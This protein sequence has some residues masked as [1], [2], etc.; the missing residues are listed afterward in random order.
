MVG[1]ERRNK[2]LELLN[3][4]LGSLSGS[5]LSKILKVS[6]QVV[7]QDIAILR[8]EGKDIIATP[9]G[10]II[11]DYFSKKSAK[12]IIACK[13]H[14][15]DIGD[16]LNLIIAMGGRILDVIVEHPVYGELKGMLMLSSIMDA[17]EFTRRM[18]ESVSEPLLVLTKGVHLHTIEAD[19]EEKLNMIEEKLREKGY[20]LSEEN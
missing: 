20:L 4:G 18:N 11:P 3:S 19:S 14:G 5:Y 15:Q 12:R 13:H 17:E 2:I 1:I 8:A 10:Y 7:V 9:Q 6:R 16:E